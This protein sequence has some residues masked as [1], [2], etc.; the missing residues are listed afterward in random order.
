MITGSHH[1]QIY[2]YAT[3][4][5]RLLGQLPG[6]YL[7]R[8]Q[9]WIPRRMAVLHPPERRGVLRNRPLEQHVYRVPRDARQAAIRHA[10]RIA[11]ARHADR[12]H[13]RRPSSASR[14]SR[15]TGQATTHA[16]VQ[17][18]P[19][20]P[21]RPAP[22]RA[23]RR[24]PSC[25]RRGSIRGCRRRYADSATASGSSTTARRAAG[26]R[27]GP[28]L[29]ARRRAVGHALSSRSRRRT[30]DSPTM[31]ALLADDPGFVRDSFWPDGMVR[32][33]GR[34]Y[35]GLI[36]SPCFK[37]ATDPDRT[38]SCFSCHTMHK[39][40]D[41]PRPMEEWADDQLADRHG[42]QRRLPAVPRVA[43]ART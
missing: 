20:A 40:A 13:D 9:R 42:R 18:Q 16:R 37:N 34:E 25:N 35:N 27:G 5:Q 14:A 22:D 29:P 24:R 3:G 26:Q 32:V 17:S 43:R 30:L 15:V 39:T 28:A 31:K 4:Q 11:A 23:A 2:W 41:D 38:L 10:V 33:S 12:R 1:Q 19:A 6:A 8:E 7:I 36:E 21:L